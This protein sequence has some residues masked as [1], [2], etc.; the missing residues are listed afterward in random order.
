MQPKRSGQLNAPAPSSASNVHRVES[1]AQEHDVRLEPNP[2]KN[3]RSV[4][5]GM[6]E[7]EET[8]FITIRPHA[9]KRRIAMKQELHSPSPHYS[10]M[11]SEIPSRSASCSTEEPPLKGLEHPIS[12]TTLT[13]VITLSSG[14]S[15][16]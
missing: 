6:S 13:N 14:K 8:E 5:L 11:T 4:S 2:R 15:F 9:K 7:Q 12:G 3:R 16:E 1:D 10:S